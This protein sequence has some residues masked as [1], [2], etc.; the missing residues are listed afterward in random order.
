M[1]VYYGCVNNDLIEEPTPFLKHHISNRKTEASYIKCPAFTDYYKNVF[2]VKFPYDYSLS[3]STKDGKS[4]I[5]T[6]FYDQSFFNNNV[7]VRSLDK[8]SGL[9]SLLTPQVL[10]FAEK[11]LTMTLLAPSMEYNDVNNFCQVIQ[12]EYDI[13]K[14]ARAVETAMIIPSNEKILFK[15]N[16]VLHYIKFNTDEKVHFKRFYYTQELDDLLIPQGNKRSY[17]NNSRPLQF[18]YDIVNKSGVIK[19][20]K[21]NIKQNVMED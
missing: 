2:V 15:E 20:I 3:Y 1:I 18:W 4:E 7:L 10:Y 21:K 6:D 5:E 11:P 8:D 14:H 13:G 16:D 12:G 19:K 9:V 17:T